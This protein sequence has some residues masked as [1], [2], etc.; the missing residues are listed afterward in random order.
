[1]IAGREALA[2]IR[3]MLPDNHRDSAYRRYKDIVAALA[4]DRRLLEIG[5]GRRPLFTPAE[6]KARNIRYPANDIMQAELA[7]IPFPV[8]TA[9]IDS[10]ATIPP[11]CE[12]GS[13]V[14]ST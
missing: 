9:F 10:S 1:M 7:R 5:A 3:D 4:A 11:A 14:T 6:I 13:D 8:A 2:V 12:R